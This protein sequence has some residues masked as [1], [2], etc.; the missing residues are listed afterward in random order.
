MKH[1]VVKNHEE[2]VEW[3]TWSKAEDIKHNKK[4]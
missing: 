4:E 2:E 1:E 3:N